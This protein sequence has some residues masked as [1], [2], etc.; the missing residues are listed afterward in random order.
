M[1]KI[2]H[3]VSNTYMKSAVLDL[4]ISCGPAEAG[5][6]SDKILVVRGIHRLRSL[7]KWHMTACCVST[8]ENEQKKTA[9]LARAIQ[10]N[11]FA[12]HFPPSMRQKVLVSQAHY[13]ISPVSQITAALLLKMQGLGLCLTPTSS[14]GARPKRAAASGAPA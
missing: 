10:P 8:R 6:V 2:D 4:Q 1:L 5:R 12:P 7:F 14:D 9:R 13:L 3:V 11:H